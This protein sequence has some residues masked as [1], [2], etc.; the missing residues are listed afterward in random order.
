MQETF[1]LYVQLDAVKSTSGKD[2]WVFEGIAS[3]DHEDL[4]G[5]VVYPENFE[6]S[7]DFFRS[8]GKIYFNH[9]YAQKNEDWLKNHGF[10][11]EQI[12]SLKMPIGKPLDAQLTDEGL[13]IKAVLNKEHPLSSFVWNSFM[14][15]SDERFHD[16]M[17]LSIGAKYLGAPRREYDVL[18][19]KYVTY[20]PDLLLYEVSVTP[21]P[22][23]PFTKTWA[24]AMKS[25][26]ANLEVP[27]AVSHHTIVP[28]EV[29]YD[30]DRDVLVVKS[31]VVGKS[32]ETHVFESYIDVKED[33]KYIMPRTKGTRKALP[34]E[35]EA[36]ME[37]EGELDTDLDAAE[38]ALS[39]AADILGEE[40]DSL[41]GEELG[42][43]EAALGDDL[44]GD[45]GGDPA[46]G[47][48]ADGLLDS[49]VGDESGDL[50][51]PAEDDTQAMILDKL[52]SILDVLQTVADMDMGLG[53][54]EPDV[55][56]L[57]GEGQV[58]NEPPALKSTTV[59]LSDES[60]EKFGAA[61]KGILDGWEDRVVEK[62]I[63]KLTNE[64]TV[65]KSVV[66]KAE[67]PKVIHPGVS[68]DSTK[69]ADTEIVQKSVVDYPGKSNDLTEEDEVVLKSLVTEYASIRG[70]GQAHAQKRG[71][72]L[73]RAEEQLGISQPQFYQFV[74]EYENATK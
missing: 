27:S 3:T 45:L 50:G 70:Y 51:E 13:Y 1:Q 42:E 26:M 17:G 30:E 38:D 54:V 47:D 6:K 5:E 34:G 25:M 10:S 9:L 72:V 33:I 32:G 31:T 48:E 24:Y 15:N 58:S 22:V 57:P 49:L 18:K 2:D 12:L 20:L 36:L 43:E 23:N 68:V 11:Q 4:F 74:S 69:V 39:E 59:E 67:Q 37:D 46:M 65:V 40:D 21:E 7:I 63:E 19:G 64:T 62:I 73:R 56:D 61:L 8:N 52:D 41:E 55:G 35:D 28:D 14:K 29:V 16:T 44:G 71:R 60:T 53:G 66:G